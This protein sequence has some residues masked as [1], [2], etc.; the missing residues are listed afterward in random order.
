MIGNNKYA[1]LLYYNNK[2]GHMLHVI[3]MKQHHNKLITKY[4]VILLYLSL[5]ST[6]S[7]FYNSFKLEY[8]F[9]PSIK[10]LILNLQ[11]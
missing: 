11:H 8:I 3:F 2:L 5:H 7:Y 10:F 1:T 4:N 9:T 6:I